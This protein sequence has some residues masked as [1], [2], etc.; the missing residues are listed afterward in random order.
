M[1]FLV[2]ILFLTHS[3]LPHHHHNGIPHFEFSFS[4]ESNHVHHHNN[5]CCPC[6][7]NSEE[8]TCSMDKDIDVIVLSDD[9]DCHCVSCYLSHEH[10]GMLLQAILLIFDYEVNLSDDTRNLKE[11]PY[12][13]S[14]QSVNAGLGLGLRAPPVI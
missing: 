2:N 11:P 9:E 3:I 10:P 6:K 5:A 4:S 8:G 14:Y 13:I 7:S 1:I 12:L